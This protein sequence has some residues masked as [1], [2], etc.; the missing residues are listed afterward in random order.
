MRS[1]TYVDDVVEGIYTLMHSDLEGPANIGISEY[2]SVDELVQMVIKASGKS[3]DVKHID[4]PVGV[5]SR[6]FSHERIESLGWRPKFSLADGIAATYPWI[7]AQ[8]AAAGLEGV[9]A[10]R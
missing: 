6:N 5:Q 10:T 9:S 3:L 7:E 4:G 8:V 1:Y 2:V